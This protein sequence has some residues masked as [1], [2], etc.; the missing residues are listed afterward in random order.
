MFLFS[1]CRPTGPFRHSVEEPVLLQSRRRSS[2]GERTMSLNAANQQEHRHNTHTP[3]H[4]LPFTHSVHPHSPVLSLTYSPSRFTVQ[5]LPLSHTH[6]FRKHSHTILG[7]F[8]LKSF[9]LSQSCVLPH[10]ILSHKW[11]VLL[12]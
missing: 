6:I 9:T 10:F 8:H 11:I 12:H 2:G 3:T 4:I 1:T 5:Y 7:G